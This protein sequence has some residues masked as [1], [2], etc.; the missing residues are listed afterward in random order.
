MTPSL[1]ALYVGPEPE[2][3]VAADGGVA[4]RTG[5]ADA[6]TVSASLQGE[7]QLGLSWLI[8]LRWGAVVGQILAIFLVPIA[9]AIELPTIALLALVGVTALTNAA[10]YGVRRPAQG[11]H[12]AAVLGLDVALLTAMLALSGGASNPFT[13]FFLVH[14]ALAALLLETPLAWTL[15]AA[16]VAAFGLLFFA[17]AGPMSLH[18]HGGSGHLVGMWV[19]YALSAAFVTHF[20]AKVSRALRERDHR[21]ASVTRLAQKNERLATLSSFSA[22]AAH[23][24]GS[25]LAT[26]GIAAKELA[27]GLHKN[28]PASGLIEDAEL[29][30]REIA[31]CRTILADLSARA[32]ESMGEMPTATT[33][34]AVVSEVLRLASPRVAQLL[35]VTYAESAKAAPMVAPM[36]TLAQMIHNLVRNA[37]EA[38]D[39]RTVDAPIELCVEAGE[40]VC[41][42]VRDRGAGLPEDVRARLGEPFVTT[43]AGHGGLGLGIYLARAYAERTGGYLVFHARS[44]GGTDAE[45]C[46][47]RNA[48]GASR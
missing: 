41:F 35:V 42:H 9:L 45:L 23:E 30:C 19:A 43:K 36:R 20:V 26:I 16:T 17:P 33:P 2:E 44:G 47:A 34:G 21:L 8:R 32:G 12:L 4:V 11:V 39:E 37:R 10:L 3:P 31:R 15:V 29:V 24:L 27:L 40:R 14:V 25:P 6:A 1:R 7:Q 28:E 48:I 46:L 38:Q 13:V 18:V 22:H 5:I